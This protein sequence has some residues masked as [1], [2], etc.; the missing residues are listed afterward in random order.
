MVQNKLH[1]AAH[2]HTAAEVIYKRADADEPFMGLKSFSGDFPVLKDISIA[3][4]YLNDEELKILN[5]IVS[6]YFDFA[7]IQAMRHNPMY[8]ADY[9]E[10][11]DN[12][13]KTTGEKVLHG[14]GT[15]SH[16]QAIEKATKE[17]RKYQEKNLSPVEEVYL[18]TIKNI[19][20]KI[21]KNGD[22]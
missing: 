4:N 7:E 8:M 19:Q 12:L 16:T 13:L 14:A 22:S 1:Y 10:Y 18:E 11:L 15:I 5:N 21:K 17:Y 20:S 3:K 2:G 9:V 6:G